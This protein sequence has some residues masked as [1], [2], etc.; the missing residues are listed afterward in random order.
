[1]IGGCFVGRQRCHREPQSAQGRNDSRRKICEQVPAACIRCTQ[2]E[3]LLQ[4][5]G[6]LLDAK[7]TLHVVISCFGR[8]GAQG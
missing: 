3:K 6:R 1:V 5:C 7:N 8:C 4:L 2:D